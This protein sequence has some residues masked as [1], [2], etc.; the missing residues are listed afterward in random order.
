MIEAEKLLRSCVPTAEFLLEYSQE[1]MMR[2]QWF[3][4]HMAKARHLIQSSLKQMDLVIELLDARAPKSSINP[5]LRKLTVSKP[6]LTLLNKDDL[7]DPVAT[8]LWANWYEKE[9]MQ[10][11]LRISASTG[12]GV[13]MIAAS[14][15][16]LLGDVKWMS[17]RPTRTLLLGI[18]NSGKSTLINTLIGRRRAITS[19][20]P[21]FTRGLNRIPISKELEIYDSPG[22]LYHKFEGTGLILASIGAIKETILPDEEVV[23]ELLYYMSRIYPTQLMRN[24]N[25]DGLNSTPHGL[26]RQV[27]ISRGCISI[28]T[29]IDIR[30][31]AQTVLKDLR[32]GKFGRISLEWPDGRGC[33]HSD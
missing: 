2:I 7:A 21:G 19:A 23:G 12:K 29:K 8:K 27:G 10:L 32:D 9:G 4:G 16:K 20:M 30:R 24:Y 3:P 13:F 33:W 15:R 11:P 22:L 6:I 28:G 18:P 25:L 1:A 17:R 26:F 31:T 5:L 14:C